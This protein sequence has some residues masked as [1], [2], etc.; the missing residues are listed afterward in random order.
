MKTY[1]YKVSDEKVKK[2]KLHVNT[3]FGNFQAY[4]YRRIPSQ[5]EIDNNTGKVLSKVVE[6]TENL[7]KDPIVLVIHGSD[8]ATFSVVVQPIL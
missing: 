2:V 5:K 8:Y 7:L 1:K 3:L 4:T 6:F